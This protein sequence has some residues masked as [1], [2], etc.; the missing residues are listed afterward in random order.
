[1]EEKTHTHKSCQDTNV[2]LIPCKQSLGT[3]GWKEV[4]N[5]L[6]ICALLS[7]QA[8]MLTLP[9]HCCVGMGK[10]IHV[11]DSVLSKRGIIMPDSDSVLEG[12]A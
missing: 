4:W 7:N 3:L 12:S 9:E 6:H 11:P 1:M 8:V 10:P 2:H 5:T